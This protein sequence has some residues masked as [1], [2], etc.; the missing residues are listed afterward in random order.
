MLELMYMKTE[1][2]QG[3]HV[4]HKNCSLGH[5]LCSMLPNWLTFSGSFSVKPPS[6]LLYANCKPL[7]APV[8]SSLRVLPC[9]IWAIVLLQYYFYSL[10]VYCHTSHNFYASEARL[11]LFPFM[12]ILT[13]I[14]TFA[15]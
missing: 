11:G 13:S 6:M 7:S 9:L 1:C 2:A 3:C 4:Y 8:A 5:S 12:P 15:P 10:S 14:N